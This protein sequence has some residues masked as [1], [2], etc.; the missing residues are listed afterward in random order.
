MGDLFKHL[1]LKLTRDGKKVAFNRGAQARL[2]PNQEKIPIFH[3]N[4]LITLKPS[5][6]VTAEVI[7]LGDWYDVLEPG[8]YEL[9]VWRVWGKGHK[10]NPVS[11]EDV[12]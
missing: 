8:S 5:A 1:C 4:A 7:N 3:E 2:D 12:P 11:F 10:S 6:T 9:T